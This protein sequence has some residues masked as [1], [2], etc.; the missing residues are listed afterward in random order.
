MRTLEP[1]ETQVMISTH[2]R[3]SNIDNIKLCVSILM[4]LLLFGVMFGVKFL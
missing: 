3:I 2:S 4:W 1:E